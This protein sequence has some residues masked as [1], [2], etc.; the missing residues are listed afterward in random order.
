M[1]TSLDELQKRL[2]DSNPYWAGGHSQFSGLSKDKTDILRTLAKALGNEPAIY[3]QA[4]FSDLQDATRS[5]RAVALTE[6]LIVIVVWSSTE[7]GAVKAE[8]RS[9]RDVKQIS[10][11]PAASG[12]RYVWTLRYAKP[13]ALVVLGGDQQNEA[14]YNELETLAPTLNADLA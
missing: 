3:V 12:G 4:A 5:I 13:E 2:E 14:N 7:T 11:Q 1:T 10:I 9:R 6:R 8:V